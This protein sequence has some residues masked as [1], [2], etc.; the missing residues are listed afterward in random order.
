MNEDLKV[1]LANLKKQKKDIKKELLNNELYLK[2]LDAN[3]EIKEV[4]CE[5][6]GETPEEKKPKPVDENK[7]KPSKRTAKNKNLLPA[8]VVVVN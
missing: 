8:P 7:P 4:V 6:I 2:F 5:L 1:K 3:R